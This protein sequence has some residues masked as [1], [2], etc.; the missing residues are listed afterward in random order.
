MANASSWLGCLVVGSEAGRRAMKGSS[1]KGLERTG[2]GSFPIGLAA[3]QPL[4]GSQPWRPQT[5]ADQPAPAIRR[6]Q[7]L[8]LDAFLRP[9]QTLVFRST[10]SD[11]GG[12][13]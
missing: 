9:H 4:L 2:I 5:R 11:L 3:G 13:R 8:V 12:R 7:L 6:R 10:S 1:W